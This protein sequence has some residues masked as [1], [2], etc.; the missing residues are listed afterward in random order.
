MSALSSS[1]L[2]DLILTQLKTVTTI[3]P[4]I[5]ENG[6][7][8]P[9]NPTKTINPYDAAG[10]GFP[11]TMTYESE[12]FAGIDVLIKIISEQLISHVTSAIDNK[13]LELTDIVQGHLT[14]L[15][16][17]HDAM[18]TALSLLT[19]P[20]LTPVGL[21]GVAGLVNAVPRTANIVQ[22]EAKI[23]ERDLLSKPRIEGAV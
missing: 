2:I 10:Q 3:V 7:V 13:L 1:V 12:L 16:T 5:D 20:P 9:E 23:V 4:N 21:A 11:L 22:E 14:L 17:D 19:V 8:D 18:A 6:V 15:N